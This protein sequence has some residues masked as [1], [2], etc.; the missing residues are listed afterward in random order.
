M[1]PE[2]GREEMEEIG[3][4]IAAGNIIQAI[5]LY[6]GITGSGLRESKEFI[7]K[8]RDE[9][10][11]AQP[12]RFAVA[13]RGGLHAAQVMIFWMLWLGMLG[14]V[15]TIY[16]I[17]KSQVTAHDIHPRGMVWLAGAIPVFLSVAVRWAVLPRLARFRTALACFIVGL[18]L[19]EATCFQ[20]V[21]IFPLHGEQ[22][23]AFGLAGML[24]FAPVFT[25][26]L[27]L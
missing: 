17:L 24:Q 15:I 13:A 19:A 1:P 12:E 10:R 7:E 16:S 18:A 27:T 4:A 23:F 2:P 26:K 5:K 14:C 22:L 8:L 20:G 9:L 11:V 6:R 25:R 21:F 3:N